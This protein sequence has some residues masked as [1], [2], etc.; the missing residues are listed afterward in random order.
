LTWARLTAGR[1]APQRGSHAGA[2]YV[3][4]ERALAK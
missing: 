4:L 2:F 1:S 3:D